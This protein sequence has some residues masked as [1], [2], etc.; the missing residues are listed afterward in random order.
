[1]GLVVLL[2]L[3]SSLAL[4]AA[5]DFKPQLFSEECCS[6]KTVGRETYNQV[7]GD[8]TGFPDCEGQCVYEKE[9]SRFCFQ[10]GGV[11][12]EPAACTESTLDSEI[13]EVKRN[14]NNEIH[15]ETKIGKLR[16]NI[17]DDESDVAITCSKTEESSTEDV[18][19][20][21]AFFFSK[22]PDAEEL[23]WT[24]LHSPSYFIHCNFS[25]SLPSSCISIKQKS[26]PSTGSVFPTAGP[27]PEYCQRP[28][29]NLTRANLT[30]M[31]GAVYTLGAQQAGHSGASLDETLKI[32]SERCNNCTEIGETKQNCT[33]WTLSFETNET[34][35][36]RAHVN[37]SE[38]GIRYYKPM[39][40]K[41]TDPNQYAGLR[42]E[43]LT[44]TTALKDRTFVYKIYPST[45]LQGCHDKCKTDTNPDGTN[46]TN[47]T[48]DM[49]TNTCALN[50]YIPTRLINTRRFQPKKPPS[51]V[52]G[53]LLAVCGGLNPIP[54]V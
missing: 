48:W 42:P 47:W 26:P 11:N 10:A 21:A 19:E 24:S 23:E 50:N 32:C 12:P 46:C 16:C 40:L 29:S 9:G 51:L 30:S 54:P 2:T 22:S 31:H 3:A 33:F 28:P 44:N 18:V 4:C 25:N 17:P 36:S 20:K 5:Q 35:T 1:M 13:V 8:T 14:S 7:A 38:C 45:S 39:V 43:S 27:E 53:C 34:T 6:K 15:F 52:S 41:P 49:A 37:I